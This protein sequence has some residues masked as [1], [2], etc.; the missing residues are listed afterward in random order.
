MGV[1]LLSVTSAA[2]AAAA[3]QYALK[4]NGDRGHRVIFA[5]N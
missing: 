4:V 2:A 1:T 3:V 5:L